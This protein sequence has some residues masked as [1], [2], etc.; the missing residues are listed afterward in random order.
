MLRYKVIRAVFQWLAVNQLLL[1]EEGAG[2][3]EEVWT[4]LISK[5]CVLVEV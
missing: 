3:E 1:Q 2:R 4:F 5:S